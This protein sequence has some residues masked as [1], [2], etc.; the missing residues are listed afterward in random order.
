MKKIFTVVAF[1]MLTCIGCNCVKGQSKV[2]TRNYFDINLCNTILKVP[3]YSPQEMKLSFSSSR[4]NN[5]IERIAKKN[6]FVHNCCDTLYSD[7][8]TG[9]NKSKEFKLLIKQ[10]SP[11]A[12]TGAF[13]IISFHYSNDVKAIN[14]KYSDG[15][16]SELFLIY[17]LDFKKDWYFI[18][19]IHYTNHTTSQIL[20]F[21][22]GNVKTIISSYD[23]VFL[24]LK[25]EYN[26]D[27]SLKNEI[28][29]DKQYQL[30]VGQVLDIINKKEFCDFFLD[31]KPA[32]SPDNGNLIKISRFSTE[33]YGNVW[34]VRMPPETVTAN[35]EKYNKIKVDIVFVV[36]E[37]RKILVN[38]SLL[39]NEVGFNNK[40]YSYIYGNNYTL[41]YKYSSDNENAINHLKLDTDKMLIIVED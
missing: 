32:I 31:N 17:D 28:N 37:T 5:E 35:N 26:E 36:D 40:S 30:N 33:N 8:L 14:V 34:M 18:H 6:N 12:R 38:D 24:G 10:I 23:Y 41:Y 2:A 7:R 25:S 13:K 4:F 3:L 20:Y 1:L 9:I 16:V 21:P 29:Y 39:F 19:S 15:T 11:K 22:T 27:G